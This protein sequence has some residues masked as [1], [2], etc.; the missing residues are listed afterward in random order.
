MLAS[1][2]ADVNQLLQRAAAA[3]S[4]NNAIIAVV[5]RDG[6]ILGVKVESGVNVTLQGLPNTPANDLSAL[7][8]SI[9]GA[10]ALARSAAFFSS[11]QGPL[12]SRTVGFVSQS[13]ITQREVQSDPDLNDPTS[14][15]QG[16]GVVARVGV[17]GNFP[18]NALNTPS[19]D[20]FGIEFND[21]DTNLDF[22]VP[23]ADLTAADISSTQIINTES[24]GVAS[25]LL[26]TAQP[27]GIGTLPG[28]IPLY[29]NGTLVGGI[30]VFF[31]GPHGYAD[32]EQNFTPLPANASPTAEQNAEIARTDTILEQTAEWMAFAATNGSSGASYTVGTL[33]SSSGPNDSSRAG[34]QLARRPGH[35]DQHGRNYFG[36]SGPGRAVSRLASDPSHRRRGRFGK[37][38]SSLSLGGFN[39]G[40]VNAVDSAAS[41]LN[42]KDLGSGWLVTPHGTATQIAQENQIINAGI[43]Q[44]N[45]TRSAIRQL[46]ST[47]K[48][49]FAVTDTERQR[50]GAVS[51]GGCADFFD[52]RGGGQGPQRCLLRFAATATVGRGSRRQVGDRTRRRR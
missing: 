52:R 31:P 1:R 29:K 34:L 14:V 17:G 41:Y 48:M 36:R 39:P 26:P 2:S 35:A 19:A 18:I 8:F 50:A 6:D 37:S 51:N 9:D 25:G 28:G 33:H 5:D 45:S 20:L 22:N 40:N 16:P 42:G 10:V 27:R 44:A 7:V 38:A 4:R 23:S 12:T 32:F 30:A 24:Y 21:R 15:Y 3:S 11:N 49:I 46:G 43:A 13:T 47:A